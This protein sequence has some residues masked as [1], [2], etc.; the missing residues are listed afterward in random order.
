LPIDHTEAGLLELDARLA[1][2][3][4]TIGLKAA[5]KSFEFGNNLAVDMYDDL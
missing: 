4:S 2:I 1:E 3:P 5:E